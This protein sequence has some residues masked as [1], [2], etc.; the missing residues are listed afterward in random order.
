MKW[1]VPV[2]VFN[3]NKTLTVTMSFKERI[4]EDVID[5]VTTYNLTTKPC[6]YLNLL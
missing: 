2:I 1:Q 5:D 6:N 3:L 4:K